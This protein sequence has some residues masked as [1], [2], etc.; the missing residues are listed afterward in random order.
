MQQILQPQTNVLGGKLWLHDEQHLASGCAH[1]FG[2]IPN[3]S[4]EEDDL[5]ADSS[6]AH[7]EHSQEGKLQ[8]EKNSKLSSVLRINHVSD[9]RRCSVYITRTN[10]YLQCSKPYL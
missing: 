8:L 2:L 3:N 5:L 4:A 6:F 9:D 1:M 7:S 10:A